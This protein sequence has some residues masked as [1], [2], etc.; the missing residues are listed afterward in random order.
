MSVHTANHFSVFN[1]NQFIQYS[2]LNLFHIIVLFPSVGRK[3][4]N[5]S[6]IPFQKSLKVTPLNI[7]I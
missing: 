2:K 6:I 7:C 4:T 3:K 5:L 1:Y